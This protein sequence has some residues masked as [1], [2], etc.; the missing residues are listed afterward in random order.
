MKNLWWAWSLFILLVILSIQCTAENQLLIPAGHWSYRSMA[1]L[2]KDG[3]F[4]GN[5]RLQFGGDILTR[6]EMAYYLKQ[7][8]VHLEKNQLKVKLTDRQTEILNKLIEEFQDELR[9]LGINITDLEKMSPSLPHIH[10]EK[11]EG[12]FD[13]DYV[14][15]ND[16][17]TTANKVD[18]TIPN[19]SEP[20]YFMGEYLTSD[21]RQKVFFFSPE[22]YIEPKLLLELKVNNRW[23]IL[24]SSGDYLQISFIIV[25]GS[26]PIGSTKVDGYYF[27]PLENNPGILDANTEK[28]I[29]DLLESLASKY[30]VNNL[31]QFKGVLPFSKSLGKEKYARWQ[32]TNGLQIGAFLIHTLPSEAI[33]TIPG[34]NQ[35]NAGKFTDIDE[36]LKN[37]LFVESQLFE[38]TPNL[39]PSD[40]LALNN[41]DL[42]LNWN[43]LV[44]STTPWL[45][46]REFGLN[47]QPLSTWENSPWGSPLNDQ[48]SRL[49]LN[50]R[51]FAETSLLEQ[52]FLF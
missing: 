31:W 49:M 52:S 42:N 6:Y 43:N 1:E 20:Y 2:A 5:I 3:L 46:E 14:L 22:V 34:N 4:A 21:L 11:D 47:Q 51:L 41:S 38:S 15:S 23:D 48:W 37:P 10:K 40:I 25:K 16:L 9:M 39:F 17:S 12:Y 29:Y 33:D 27:F 19:L 50:F 30:E 7:L 36:W 24:Y 32:M 8:I 44:T 45:T 18:L 35:L 28:T 13:L 26:F